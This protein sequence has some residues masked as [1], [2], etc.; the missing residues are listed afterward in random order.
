MDTPDED[1]LSPE[2]AAIF[3]EQFAE[4]DKLGDAPEETAVEIPINIRLN[5]LSVM[6]D[7][8]AKITDNQQKLIDLTLGALSQ[9]DSPEVNN[10]LFARMRSLNQ[11]L[12]NAFRKVW[13]NDD[14]SAK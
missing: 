3:R 1:F 2:L 14:D 4:L 9:S 12:T 8:L 6:V 5:N 11:D 7:Y 10:D 13:Y